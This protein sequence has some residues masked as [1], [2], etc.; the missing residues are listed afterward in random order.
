M[1]YQKIFG[2]IVRTV[3]LWSIILGISSAFTMIRV[4]GGLG[5]MSYYDWQSEGLFVVT[6]LIGG[7]FL[8]RRAELVVA[9]AYPAK[10]E[11]PPP[12]SD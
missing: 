12:E 9:F 4:Y 3:G 6:Y 10:E 5:H 11:S 7:V 1:D 8:L 2:V